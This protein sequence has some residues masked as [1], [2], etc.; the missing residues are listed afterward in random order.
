MSACRDCESQVTKGCHNLKPKAKA[1]GIRYE[2]PRPVW[3]SESKN[4]QLSVDLMDH[5]RHMIALCYLPEI[6]MLKGKHAHLYHEA[7]RVKPKWKLEVANVLHLSSASF[8]PHCLYLDHSS[9]QLIMLEGW[10][11]LFNNQL[12]RGF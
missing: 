1:T 7:L 5:S 11:V 9:R 3:L 2:S 12:K 4:V 8:F 6:K 10:H